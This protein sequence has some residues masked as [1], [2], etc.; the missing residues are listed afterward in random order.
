MYIYAYFNFS[1][2]CSLPSQQLLLAQQCELFKKIGSPIIANVRLWLF[3]PAERSN[4][5]ASQA[6]QTGNMII[7]NG[8]GRNNENSFIAGSCNKRK[9]KL[10]FSVLSAHISVCVRESLTHTVDPF[11]FPP[12]EAFPKDF[13]VPAVDPEIKVKACNQLPSNFAAQYL[14]VVINDNERCETLRIMRPLP[15]QERILTVTLED[16]TYYVGLLGKNPV[17]L[18]ACRPGGDT[19]L[20]LSPAIGPTMALFKPK[21]IISVG[22][23]FGAN[24]TEQKLGDVLLSEKVISYSVNAQQGRDGRAFRGNITT[25]SPGLFN[26]LFNARTGWALKRPGGE[27]VKVHVGP[28]LSGN[29]FVDSDAFKQELLRDHEGQSPIGGEMEVRTS[30][31]WL[32]LFFKG[33]APFSVIFFSNASFQGHILSSQADARKVSWMIVKAISNW[34][35]GLNAVQPWQPWAAHVAAKFVSHAFGEEDGQ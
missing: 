27:Y 26:L 4:Q 9:K 10:I 29:D 15:S 13:F 2:N 18:F 23:A 7:D 1:L 34:G 11:P 12:I 19:T 31:F 3:T 17:A 20:G 6:L 33:F 21:G 8:Q 30:C 28:F 16:N 25:P 24:P 5:T 32:L 22:V 14:V 35:D